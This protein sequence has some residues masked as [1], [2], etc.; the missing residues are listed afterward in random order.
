MSRSATA[1]RSVSCASRR[2]RRDAHRDGQGALDLLRERDRLCGDAFADALGQLRGLGGAG[3]G[4]QD[5]K[6]VAAEARGR[7]HAA[8]LGFDALRDLLERD[9]ARQVPIAV[10]DALEV[11]DVHHQA[12]DGA[13][14]ALSA[15]ELLLQALLQI[16]AVVPPGQEIG[17]ARAQQPGPVDGVLDAHRG[18]RAQMREKVGAVMAREPGRGP[19]CRSTGRRWQCPCGAGAPGRRFSGSD[20]PGNSR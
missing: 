14:L 12:G 8:N 3:V 13:C 19:G 5:G 20:D 4:Q 15:R 17:D 18:D 11:V 10:V 7:I 1:F 16:A 6:L 9:V 2:E